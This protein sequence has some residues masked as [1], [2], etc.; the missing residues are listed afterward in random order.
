MDAEY[1][2]SKYASIITR[3][4]KSY[5]E[6]NLKEF[7]IG[8]SQQFFLIMIY[9]KPGMSLADVASES[10]FDKSTITRSVKKLQQLGYIKLEDDENDGRAFRLYITD[11]GIPVIKRINE[12]KEQINRRLVTGLSDDEIATI[13]ELIIKIADNAN[14]NLD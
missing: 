1:R 4:C 11:K 6:S 10:G 8:N 13:T 3:Q 2:F 12:T 9:K 14:N 5:Y 7:G